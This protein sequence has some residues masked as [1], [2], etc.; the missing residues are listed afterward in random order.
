MKETGNQSS[1]PVAFENEKI[2]MRQIKALGISQE[3]LLFKLDVIV[4]SEGTGWG[5][6]AETTEGETSR[7][8]QEHDMPP[9]SDSS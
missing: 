8:G 7:R 2:L 3:R 4:T 5:T 1:K 9:K 6:V